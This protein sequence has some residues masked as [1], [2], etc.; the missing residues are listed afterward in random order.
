MDKY[1]IKDSMDELEKRFT[2][3]LNKAHD[4]G[5]E[6]GSFELRDATIKA[7]AAIKAR[8]LILK[9][10]IGGS[11]EEIDTNVL[12]AIKNAEKL[13]FNESPVLSN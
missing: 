1:P 2:R 12:E 8:K 5:I 7:A 6:K 10:D 13:L 11:T 4:S 3:F 9:M